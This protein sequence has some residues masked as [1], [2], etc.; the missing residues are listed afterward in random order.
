M[1]VSVGKV[2]FGKTSFRLLTHSPVMIVHRLYVIV[3]G[4]ITSGVTNHFEPES[5]FLVQ[6]HAKGYHFNAYT[7]EI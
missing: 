2:T 5:Y 7:Y 1:L 4:Y 3:L 6:I